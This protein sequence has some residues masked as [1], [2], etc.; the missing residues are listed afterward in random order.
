MLA[1]VWF[2]TAAMI[3][4]NY[5]RPQPSVAPQLRGSAVLLVQAVPLMLVLFVL[6]PRVQGPLWGM[7]ADSQRASTGLS[8]TMSPGSVSDLTLSDAVAFRVAF[9]SPMPEAKRM[10]WRGPVLWDYD[11]RTWHA[12][13]REYARPSYDTEYRPVE[14]TVTVEPHGKVWLF[15]LDLPGRLPPRTLA[16][17]D[18][19]LISPR[20]VTTRVRYEMTSFLEYTYGVNE[21]KS[22]LDRALELPPGLNPRTTE[23]AQ[24][25]R[26]Q[27]GSDRAI[28]DA[29]YTMFSRES[30]VYTLAP[31][32][33]GQHM[34][35]EFLFD[36]KA[37]FCEHYSAAFTVLMRAAGIPAR[38]VTGYLGGEANPIGDYLIV[39]QADAHAWSEVWLRGSGWVRVDPTAAVSPARVE[40]GITALGATGTLPL[41][42]RSDNQ[43]LRQMRLTWDSLAN[44][45]NQWVLGYTPERQRS[46]LTRVGLDD[47]TWRTLAAL[48]LAATGL[49]I[50]LLAFITLRRLKVRV[51]DPVV[52][53][54]L[55]F[56]RKLGAK[57]LAR[58]SSEGPLDYA[59]RIAR[60]RPELADV[61]RDFIG[62]YVGLRYGGAQPGDDVAKL[63]KL[64]SDFAP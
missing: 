49:V 8:D 26:R 59:A 57:G 60:T 16:T 43:V 29:A 1:C 15:A 64:S 44:G 42:M 61:V 35:D 32:R 22:N 36:T 47:A 48:L 19:Q 5:A 27:Y 12:P 21:R 17:S 2:I 34:V 24:K 52:R 62:L 28:L 9:K 33:L 55:A 39:R 51:H 18:F 31:P 46:L 37:G 58:E 3:G 20:P 10:Y 50:L 53:A 25:L 7:P 23:L 13:Q 63:K 54:Y 11:G 40:R 6:F 45:W 4:V 14:Y 38:V 56:C 41:F 30:F